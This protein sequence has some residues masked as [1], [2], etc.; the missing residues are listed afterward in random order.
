M[1]NNFDP[2]SVDLALVR[3]VLEKQCG[4]FVE[5]EVVGRTRLRDEVARHLFCSVL[6]AERIVDTMINRGFLRKITRDNGQ[7]GW[8]TSQPR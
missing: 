4:A 3:G 8:S 7:T 1:E 6:D 5:G 2:K